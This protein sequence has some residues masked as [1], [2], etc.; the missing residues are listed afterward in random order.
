METQ[1]AVV[2]EVQSVTMAAPV[3]GVEAPAPENVAPASTERPAWLPEEFASPE[4]FVEAYKAL[5]AEPP[6]EPKAEQAAASGD[7][8]VDPVVE[9]V[10]DAGLDWNDVSGHYAENGSLT[11]EHYAAF[12]GA[13]IN[14]T[15]VDS[16]LAGQQALVSQFRNTVLSAAGGESTFKAAADWAGAGNL[17]AAELDA[18]NAQVESGNVEAAKLA[19]QGLIARYTKSQGAEPNLADGQG[20]AA[21]S[22]G[23]ASRAQMVAD[24]QNP[25]Y[26]KDPAFRAEVARKVQA[27][28]NLF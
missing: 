7:E 27:S 25:L 10:Q 2:G 18:Y 21:Q 5:K 14:R 23:Y 20:G 9:I 16:Y 22:P 6:Q 13:G 11:D 3:T 24:M 26:S 19:V 1:S 12:E 28:S 17:T 15:L 8:S 4:Q